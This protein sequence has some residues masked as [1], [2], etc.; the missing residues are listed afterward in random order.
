[1]ES[2]I[3]FNFNV[4]SV[5]ILWMKKKNGFSRDFINIA[6][7]WCRLNSQSILAKVFLFRGREHLLYSAV[8]MS[9]TTI[10]I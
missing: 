5:F 7:P 10:T 9:E 6:C 1:M 4:K 8:R 2:S 3:Q